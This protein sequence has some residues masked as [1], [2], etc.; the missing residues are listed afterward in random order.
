MK[1]T[2]KSLVYG[3]SLALHGGLAFFMVIAPEPKRTETVT[4][5]MAESKAPEPPAPPKAP[6]VTPPPEAAKPTPN[7]R[8]A[9]AAEAAPKA[10]AEPAAAPKSAPGA[11]SLDALPDFG[12]SLGGGD[13]PGMAVPAGGGPAAARTADTPRPAKVLAAKPAGDTCDEAPT[14]PK[15]KSVPQPLYPASAREAGVEGKVRVEITVGPDGKVVS[16]RLLSGLGHGLDEAAL[17]AARRASFEPGQRC[18]K[19]ATATFVVSMR[20]SRS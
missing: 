6:E 7:T 17:E 12:L 2:S 20:F 13:G 8:P 10:A 9:R 11:G 14:K 15:P 5:T 4:I 19:P 18:G 3:S 16:V 1:L